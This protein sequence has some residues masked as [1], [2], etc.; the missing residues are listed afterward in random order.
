MDIEILKQI[1]EMA[2]S[3]GYMGIVILAMWL[4]YKTT[5][6]GLITVAIYKAFKLMVS[7]AQSRTL[8]ARLAAEMGVKTPLTSAEE[9]KVLE[10]VRK[11]VGKK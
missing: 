3:T 10:A 2:K 8:A 1:L 6:I 11:H 9:A 5:T 7:S 4:V